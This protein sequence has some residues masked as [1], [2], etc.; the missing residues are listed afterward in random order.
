MVLLPNCFHNCQSIL[1]NERKHLK[2]WCV[3]LIFI[4][5]L[6]Y[7]VNVSTYALQ[8]TTLGPFFPTAR[9]SCPMTYPGGESCETVTTNVPKQRIGI[10]CLYGDPRVHK[11][12]NNLW[13][14]QLY[15]RIF[16]NRYAYAKK[17]GYTIV[18]TPFELIDK[19]RP[20]AWSKLL[21]IDRVLSNYDYVF[22]LDMDTVIMNIDISLESLLSQGC[23][24]SEREH[25]FSFYAYKNVRPAHASAQ[26]HLIS[27]ADVILTTDHNG[28]NTGSFL[29]RNSSFSHWLMKEVGVVLCCV[30]LCCVVLCFCLCAFAYITLAAL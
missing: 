5:W 8:A 25:K 7:A 16:E 30:V 17:H 1:I 9:R 19:S 3:G 13:N 28:P 10:V 27:D 21:A 14:Q 20:I 23:R 2:I 24:A 26:A 22:Y 15:D 6:V 29:I 12:G 18:K 4:Y 11:S